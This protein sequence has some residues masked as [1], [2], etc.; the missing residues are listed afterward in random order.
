M[1]YFFTVK[2]VPCIHQSPIVSA[3]KVKIRQ[4]WMEIPRTRPLQI[5]RKHLPARG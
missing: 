2:S 3:V 4:P 1:L 5:C